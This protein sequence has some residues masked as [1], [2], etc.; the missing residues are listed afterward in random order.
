MA[1]GARADGGDAVARPLLGPEAWPVCL[2]VAV[3]SATR[4]AVGSTEAMERTALTSP[5]Y[6]P[7]VA[8]VARDIAEAQAAVQARD[9]ERLG[10][11]AERSCLRMHASAMAAEP[12]LLYWNAG[13]MAAI[14]IVRELRQSGIAAFFTIDAGPHVKVLCATADADR[15]ESALRSVPA[16]L[17]THVA[18]P[19]VAAHVTD[20]PA[21]DAAAEFASIPTDEMPSMP[22]D[23]M[24]VPPS[25]DAGPAGHPQAQARNHPDRRA[26]SGE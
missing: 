7:W 2:V 23:E 26:E 10:V 16:V 21:T 22:T 9:L 25:E 17:R 19:G 5:Y 12:G 1:A 24:P 20:N 8:S 3:T 6:A 18:R 4:K 13:T 11:V 15:V 14:E